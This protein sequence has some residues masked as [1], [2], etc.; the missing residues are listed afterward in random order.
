MSCGAF[1]AALFNPTLNAPQDIRHVALYLP[2][3]KSQNTQAEIL[4]IL[5]P[6]LITRNILSM[7]LAVNLNYQLQLRAIEIHDIFVN[8]SLS[9]EGVAQ[10]SASFQLVPEQYFSQGAVSSEFARTLLQFWVVVK[11]DLSSVLSS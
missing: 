7:A 8:G 1:P 2:I 10:H 9:Q 5:L 11:H 6:N 3:V 4:Q